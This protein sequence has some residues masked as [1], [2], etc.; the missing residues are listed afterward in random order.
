[1]KFAGII[2]LAAA[3][4]FNVAAAPETNKQQTPVKKNIPAKKNA[5]KRLPHKRKIPASVNLSQYSPDAKNATAAFVRAVKSGARKIVFDK[6]M[7]YYL[8]PVSLRSNLTIDVC[9]GAKIK[10][11]PGVTFAAPKEKKSRPLPGLFNG[12]RVARVNINFQDDTT[13]T[14]LPDRPVF[15]FYSSNNIY[16]RNGEITGGIGVELDNCYSVRFQNTV[17]DGLKSGVNHA[18]GSWNTFSGVQFRNIAGCGVTITSD[19]FGHLPYFT[20][21]NCEF[22]NSVS[23]LLLQRKK[24]IDPMPQP[25]KNAKARHMRFN[26]RNCRFFNNS[27]IDATLNGTLYKG[28]VFIENCLFANSKNSSLQLNDFA[29]LPPQV[30]LQISNTGFTPADGNA[31]APIVVTSTNELPLGNIKIKNSDVKNP[32]HIPAVKFALKK[33]AGKIGGELPVISADGSRKY[34]QLTLTQEKN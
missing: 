25:K 22:F 33:N 15:Y 12:I 10:A 28:T 16:V 24:K 1:M 34:T 27:G 9:K 18:G 20:L 8:E 32:V 19:R 26:I 13:V 5:K 21:D 7:T 23:G 2:F 3:V 6:A 30:D 11:V 17:F 14:G 31:T 4:A 29:A